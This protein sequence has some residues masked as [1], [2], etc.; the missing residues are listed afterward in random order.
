[1][2]PELSVHK[3]GFLFSSA[4]PK[5]VETGEIIARELELRNQ[6]APD[7]HEHEGRQAGDWVTES[8]FKDRLSRFFSN[9]SKLVFGTESA[10]DAHDRF[11]RAIDAVVAKVSSGCAVVVSHGTVISLFTARSNGLDPY[12]VWGRLTCPGFIRMELPGFEVLEQWCLPD[13]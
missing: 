3:P 5:A 12:E 1:M 11:A 9:P 2:A 6:V 4:E 7:L 8:E 10:N 13:S